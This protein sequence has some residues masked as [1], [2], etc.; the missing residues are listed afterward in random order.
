MLLVVDVGNTNVK[1]GVYQDEAL[2]AQWRLRMDPERTADEYTALLAPLFAQSGLA[3]C[4]IS[5]VAAASV[6]PA[7]T[8]AVLRFCRHAF[9]RD[10]LP[11]TGLTDIGLRVAY[12]PP[13]AVGADRLMDAVA[14]VRKYGAPCVVV[15]FGTATTFNAIVAAKPGGDGLPVYLGGAICLG[16]G[17]SL[18]ALFSKAAKIP[19]VTLARPPRAIGDN[20][21]HAL[22]SGIIHGYAAL[23]TGMVARFR[24]EMDAPE[25]PVIATGGHA[26]LIA[27]ETDC[28]SVVEPL[29]T[30]EGLR[31]VYQSQH[32]K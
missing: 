8:P 4:D 2:I 18:E 19:P 28:I 16:I 12:D 6:V 15:D 1:L 5:G 29:L 14:A 27:D 22:Q 21:P 32:V 31:L 7:A 26:A 23:V 25:C 10:P 17:V 20:T 3:F 9:G 13:D 30:L 24:A 11:I